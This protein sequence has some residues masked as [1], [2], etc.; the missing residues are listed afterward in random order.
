MG[1]LSQ[2]VVHQMDVLGS[3]IKMYS[4]FDQVFECSF[5]LAFFGLDIEE[6]FYIDQ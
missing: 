4:Q 6:K 5:Q 2:L 1:Y 3:S